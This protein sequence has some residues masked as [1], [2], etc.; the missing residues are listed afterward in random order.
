MREQRP[1]NV[2]FLCTGNSARSIIAEALLNR[3]GAGRCRAF[4]AGSRPK[5]EVHPL[6]LRV[7]AR[8]GES[9]AGLR[10]KSWD[11][12]GGRDA[13]EMDFVLTLCGSAAAEPCPIWQGGPVR[14]H[15]GTEDPAAAT[16]SEAGRVAAFERAYD[17]LEHRIR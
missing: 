3:I 2:L 5:G 16:G 4:S 10:S 1:R 8:R 13:P 12:L 11:E 15:W 14:A 17:V 7:L 6:A 9:V